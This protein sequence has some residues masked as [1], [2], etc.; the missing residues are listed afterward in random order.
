[1]AAQWPGM[2]SGHRSTGVY[3]SRRAG[4]AG[5]DYST[6][7]TLDIGPG[8]RTWRRECGGAHY[9][10]RAPWPVDVEVRVVEQRQGI[11]DA[12]KSILE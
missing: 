12:I 1:M 11:K 8:W 2:P 9:Q 6:E 5:D 4:A 10:R 3:T 7:R